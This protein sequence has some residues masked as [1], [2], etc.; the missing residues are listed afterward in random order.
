MDATEAGRWN[1]LSLARELDRYG[2]FKEGTERRTGSDL[3]CEATAR[4]SR[5]TNDLHYWRSA[6]NRKGTRRTQGRLK[7]TEIH[8]LVTSLN[9]ER[10]KREGLAGCQT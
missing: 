7:A 5:I 10:H 3:D 8:E 1:G 4:G 6:D 9:L 2:G